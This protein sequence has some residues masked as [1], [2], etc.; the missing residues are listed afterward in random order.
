MN[1]FPLQDPNP[2]FD[3]L[4][5]VL[6]KDIRPDRV[7]F[8]ELLFD[9]EVVEFISR[10]KMG[11]EIP[12]LWKIINDK[13]ER[14][15]RGHDLILLEEDREKIYLKRYIDFCYRMGY[16]YVPDSLSFLLLHGLSL[17]DERVSADTAYLS[18]GK[19]AWADEG[20]GIIRSWD[21]FESF[22]WDKIKMVNLEKYY[23][24]FSENLPQGMKIVV[25]GS[26]YEQVLEK[27]LGYKGLF[28][29]LYKKPD[30]V[31]A[32]IDRWGEIVLDYYEQVAYLRS[33][34]ALFHSDDLGYKTGTMINPEM[35]KDLL[36]PWFRKYVSVA[37]RNGKRC[38]YHCCGN[39]LEIM[40]DLIDDVG[41]DAFHSFQDNI[42]PVTEY[43]E[44]YG[45]RIAVLGGVDVDKLSRL[46]GKEELR[47]YVRKILESCVPGGGYA[48]GSG[49]SIANYI[50]VENYFTMMETG[51]EWTPNYRVESVKETFGRGG[52]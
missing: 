3:K 12:S 17:P 15:A 8:A 33:V 16:D 47:S 46:S 23:D 51:L 7:H 19:R 22:H 11:R 32:V 30:L 1:S 41:F 6:E 38:W 20:E 21:D 42:I 18:R 10:E 13:I 44:R 43:K 25:I 35:I 37:H 2:S 52:N 14:F 50:P 48:L 5:S 24:F 27:L 9:A 36:F 40:D 31:R 29:M 39:V 28:Y 26:L 34:G 4:I 49:N 45:D